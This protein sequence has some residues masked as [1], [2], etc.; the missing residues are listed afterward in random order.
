MNP[1]GRPAK[2]AVMCMNNCAAILPYLISP[3][4]DE[5]MRKQVQN[6]ARSAPS[7]N[8]PGV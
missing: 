8:K 4:R 6:H 5:L 3:V 2:R 7:F 1:G